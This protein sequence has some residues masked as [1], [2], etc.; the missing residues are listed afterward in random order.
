VAALDNI[1]TIEG[2]IQ[3]GGWR[4]SGNIFGDA[5]RL[6]WYREVESYFYLYA[7]GAWEGTPR[8]GFRGHLLPEPWQKSFQ[9][10]AAPWGAF[11]AQEFMK[12]GRLQ[13]IFFKEEASPANDH[14]ITNMSYADILQHIMGV[15]AEFG[16]CNLVNGVWPEGF[17]DLNIDLANSVEPASHE[18]REG[19]F[20]SRLQEMAA[21]ELYLLFVDKTN[22]MNYI[23]HP[24]FGTLPTAVLDLDSAL[25]LEPLR[26]TSRNPEAI[27]QVKLQGSTP[28]GLPISGQYPADP[29]AGPVIF[30]KG[31]KATADTLMDT[32]AERMYKYENRDVSV[33]ATLPGAIGLL[34]ELMDRISITY[35]STD[36]GVSWTAKKFWIEGISVTLHDFFNA[37]TKLRLEAE[38]A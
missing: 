4:A 15:T 18:I 16:H 20:F 10:S 25:L 33:E 29:A 12:R 19:N 32:V 2:S 22:Q 34:L 11:T 24:M 13:G 5:D 31:F 21:I 30:R 6:D 1:G 38:N 35:S 28:A 9:S 23:P 14:Q 3:E 8:L 27:G 37:T 17:L 36:D 7:G 26:I